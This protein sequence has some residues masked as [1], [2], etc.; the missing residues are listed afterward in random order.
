MHSLPPSLLGNEG[1]PN[2]EVD[3]R[4]G[5]LCLCPFSLDW[6]HILQWGRSRSCY[7]ALDWT[8]R[9]DHFR[10]VTHTAQSSFLHL[11]PLT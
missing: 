11:T 8:G 3:L 1:P 4:I 9:R 10:D 5:N 2:L 7:F 6:V